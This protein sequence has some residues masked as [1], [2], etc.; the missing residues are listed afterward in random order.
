MKLMHENRPEDKIQKKNLRFFQTRW[1]EKQNTLQTFHDL[2][3]PLVKLFRSNISE[4]EKERLE[5]TFL[6]VKLGRFLC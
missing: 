4:R 1:V 2:Y 5:L 3:E 6:E